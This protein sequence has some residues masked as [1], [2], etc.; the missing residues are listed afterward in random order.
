MPNTLKEN[1][2]AAF[3]NAPEETVEFIQ[4]LERVRIL[5]GFLMAYLN[6][7]DWGLQP[8]G[9]DCKFKVHLVPSL[10]LG[11]ICYEVVVQHV[12]SGVNHSIIKFTI[13]QEGY[14][15]DLAIT[16]TGG[17][18]TVNDQEQLDEFIVKLVGHPRSVLHLRA[19]RSQQWM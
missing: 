12:S 18:I 10:D 14:P 13:P 17:L 1:L 9:S 5:Q 2:E 6:G 16:R 7:N 8:V 15:V 19:L 3:E 11:Q 4:T